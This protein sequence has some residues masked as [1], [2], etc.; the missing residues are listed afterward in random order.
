[1]DSGVHVAEV[2]GAYDGGADIDGHGW[3]WLLRDT[4]E[5]GEVSNKVIVDIGGRVHCCREKRLVGVSG[6]GLLPYTW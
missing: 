3:M 1:M 2:G 6:E 4:H 5:P